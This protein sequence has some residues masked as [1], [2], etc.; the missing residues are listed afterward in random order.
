[1]GSKQIAACFSERSL[2]LRD[3]SGADGQAGSDRARD[4]RR[5]GAGLSARARKLEARRE[6]VPIETA[7]ATRAKETASG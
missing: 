3:A 6:S 7:G 1:M 2:S 4:T 5:Q